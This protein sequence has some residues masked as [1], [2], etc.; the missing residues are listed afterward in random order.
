MNFGRVLTKNC[1]MLGF[2]VLKICVFHV[3]MA[4]LAYFAD[5]KPTVQLIMPA[6]RTG[7][8]I[9]AIIFFLLLVLK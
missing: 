6:V 3:R 9:D 2:E 8:N 7:K 1:P 5:M 4:F